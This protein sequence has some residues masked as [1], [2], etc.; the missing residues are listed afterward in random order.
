MNAKVLIADD[1]DLVRG[2]VEK[3]LTMFDYEVVAV[4]SG[5]KVLE[6]VNDDFD[7]IVLDINMPDLDGF[8]TLEGLNRKKS[9]IPVLFLTGA[10]SM[11]Y[12]IK[13]INL[14]AYDFITKPFRLG[15][16]RAVVKKAKKRAHRNA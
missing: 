14:G 6:V 12:A 4:E 7:V 8:Q 10:G 15:E 2:A 9:E 3:I 16:I 11:D 13:A 1:D 5:V